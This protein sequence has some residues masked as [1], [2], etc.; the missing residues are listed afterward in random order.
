MPRLRVSEGLRVALV[1]GAVGIVL[2]AV[3]VPGLFTVDEDNYLATVLALRAGR[4]TVPATDGLPAS[5]EL[6]FFDPVAGWRT[7]VTTPVASAAPPLYAFFAWP[8]SFL[9]WPG[10]VLLQMLAFLITGALVYVLIRRHAHG[11]GPAV[12]GMSL[13]L[14]GGYALEYALG[15]WPHALAAAL[16]FAAVVLA[17]GARRSGRPWI[18]AALAGLCAGLATGVRYQN[19]VFGTCVGLT[20]GLGGWS[21][22]RAVAAYGV[23]MAVPLAACSILNHARLG[24][25][26]PLS[27]G[28]GYAVIVPNGTSSISPARDAALS[29]LSRIVDF[30]W[31]PAETYI[32]DPGVRH[33]AATG[34]YLIMGAVRKSLLQSAPWVAISL[35]T[36]AWSWWRRK[37]AEPLRALSIPFAGVILLFTMAGTSRHEGL[38]INQ[39]YLLELLPLAACA[40]A[41]AVEASGTLKAVH[42]AAG[43]FGGLVAGAAIAQL[44]PDIPLRQN[45]LLHAPLFL[46]GIL[47]VTWAGSRA[48]GIARRT[49][50]VFLGLACGW[51]AAVHLRDDLP[52]ALSFRAMNFA[53]QVAAE[54][55]LGDDGRPAAILGWR[56]VA[57]GPIQL[58]H[59]LVIAD[60]SLDEGRTA[61]AL[62]DA[63]LTRGRRVILDPAFLEPSLIRKIVRGRPVRVIGQRPFS[64]IEIGV[65]GQ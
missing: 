48:S 10:L 16:T 22:L 4:V 47:V 49:L 60:T 44:H 13:W 23:G 7:N 1:L 30:S 28:P 27:K 50:P 36:L 38:A 2:Q 17:D 21:R 19:V 45:A 39:R 63:L 53:K 59:D 34:A 55:A 57:Y 32:T 56:P 37:D 31:Q 20:L 33:V 46:S 41:W 61:P 5:I 35:C 51:A 62:V 64:F 24:W 11:P 8:F 3:V 65:E 26:N 29:F 14:V 25:W 18:P 52:T 54:R 9:G 42:L 12:L 6:L 58:D 40:L 43:A 15:V